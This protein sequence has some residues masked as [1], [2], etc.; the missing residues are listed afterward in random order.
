MR[1]KHQLTLNEKDY[2]RQEE[3]FDLVRAYNFP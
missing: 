3:K 1:E 2:F